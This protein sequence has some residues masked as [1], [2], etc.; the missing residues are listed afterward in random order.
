MQGTDRRP[1]FSSAARRFGARLADIAPGSNRLTLLVAGALFVLCWPVVDRPGGV[2]LDRSWELALHLA[3]THHLHFG[4]DFIFTY[5]PLGFLTVPTPYLGL[6]SALGLVYMAVLHAGLCLAIALV[7]MQ[8]RPLWVALPVAY[9]AARTITGLAAPDA[10]GIAVAVLVGTLLVLDRR[11]VVP[12]AWLVGISALVSAIALLGKLDAGVV[13][14]VLAGLAI[15]GSERRPLKAFGVF[16]VATL[17]ATGAIWIA[18]GQHLSDLIAYGQGAIQIIVG[19]SDAMVKGPATGLQWEPLG[20][21]VALLLTGRLVVLGTAELERRRRTAILLACIL[22]AGVFT[23]IALIRWVGG[24]HQAVLFTGALFVALLYVKRGPRFEAAIIAFTAIAICLVAVSQSDP[25]RFLNPISN[26]RTLVR[27]GATIVLP[28]RSDLTVARTTAQLQAL[29]AVPSPILAELQGRTVHVDPWETSVIAAYPGIAWSPLPVLQSYSVYTPALDAAN[30]ARLA[31][32][33]APD[34][35]L[36]T[37]GFPGSYTPD[38]ATIDGR[39]RWFEAPQAM[40]ETFCRYR[41]SAILGSWQVLLRTGGQCGTPVS[42]GSVMAK[43][44]D[45]V[46]VPP[47]PSPNDFVIV[48]IIGANP[49]PFEAPPLP[50]LRASPW[51]VVVDGRPFRLVRAT[52]GDGLLLAVPDQVRGS[53]PFDFGP[54]RTSISIRPATGHDNRILDYAFYAVPLLPTGP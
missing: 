54:P 48:R 1:L 17:L 45:S 38:L 16:V 49:S 26:V 28:G 18:L 41:Q 8:L 33:D 19:Y 2:G 43:P 46:A 34:A 36:R 10:E 52:A 50:F 35:I 6:T 20:I 23:T 3:I 51:Q 12:T 25:V 47:P 30:A 5:G 11:V 31:S 7:A 32:P 53:A 39:Y 42:L 15:A 44:G 40:L 27:Q 37:P 14:T 29:L 4:T 9:V 24:P 13:V 22:V 21:L